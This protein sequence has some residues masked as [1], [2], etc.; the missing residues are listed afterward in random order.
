MN[1][2]NKDYKYIYPN[3]LNLKPGSPVHEKLK[4]L[5]LKCIRE[6]HTV[7]KNRHPQWREINRT[8]TAYVPTDDYEDAIRNA[9]PRKPL[10]MVI[11]K[12]FAT[13]DTLL[14]YFQ[15]A[16]GNNPIF[17]YSGYGADD[18]RGAKMLELV[19][20]M[21][22]IMRKSLLNLRTCWRDGFAFGIGG[23]SNFFIRDVVRMEYKRKRSIISETNIY[24]SAG[25]VDSET[26]EKE[27][28]LFEGNEIQNIDPFNIFPDPNVNYNNVQKGRYFGW[29]IRTNIQTLLNDEKNGNDI[30][31]ALYVK[32]MPKATSQYVTIDT[33]TGRA[34]KTGYISTE[35]SEIVDVLYLIVKLCPSDYELGSSRYP[36]KWIIGIA[37]D[38]VIIRAEKLSYIHNQFPVGVCS[39]DTDGHSPL[40][41]G[42]LEV[43][44][45]SQAAM[46][47]FIS[48]H[49]ANSRKTV[50]NM[51]VVDPYILNMDDLK[52]GN[53][54][55]LLRIRQEFYGEMGAVDKAIKQLQVSDVTRGNINDVIFLD[56]LMK[57]AAGDADNVVGRQRTHSGRVTATE[58]ST[59]R[60]SALGRLGAL[61][62]IVSLQ[63]HYDLAFQ[64]GWNTIQLMS[65][66]VWAEVLGDASEYEDLAPVNGKVKVTKDDIDINFNI[67]PGDGTI[68]GA[69]D[70]GTLNQLFQIIVTQP[71]LL[72]IFDV[73]KLFKTIA[74]SAGVKNISAFVNN[75]NTATVVP[76]ED[77]LREE[78]KGNLVGIGE[79]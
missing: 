75:V 42:R 36:E 16:F 55:L 18:V 12:S 52:E 53:S 68:P 6:S 27:K 25:F 22:N 11:P 60:S 74:K 64:Q 8:L 61:A 59:S 17:R 14:S 9:D 66:E 32:D 5:A 69:V 51:F 58:I 15:A 38:E 77:A 45:P 37:G 44:Y 39:P 49:V 4:E 20:G 1:Y 79:I 35:S 47:W 76:D 48:T 34:D 65:E 50:N 67:I 72:K 23:V 71:A 24:N 33:D 40:A 54:G 73:G 31:N 2:A 21:Q 28:I 3:R 41:L 30:V 29:G 13:L 63:L 57:E 62:Q 26:V 43:I 7:M 19:I 46:D 78:E 70:S 10:S 56:E